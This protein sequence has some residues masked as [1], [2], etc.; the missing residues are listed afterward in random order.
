MDAHIG[1]ARGH[2]RGQPRGNAKV[3][4]EMRELRECLEA[5]EMDR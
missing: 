2:D 4:E 5:M 3:L 1:R